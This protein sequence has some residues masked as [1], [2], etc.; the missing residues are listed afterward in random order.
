M[1]LYKANMANRKKDRPIQEI[2][3]TID[4]RPERPLYRFKTPKDRTKFILQTETVC[5]KSLEYKEYIKFLKR[6]ADLRRCTVLRGLNTEHG[7]KYS[8]EIH[9]EPFTLFDIVETVLTR[10][11]MDQE[12][13]HPLDIADEV[14]ELHY[15]GKIGLLHLSKTM[16]QMVHDDKIFIPLQYIYHKYNEFYEEYKPYIN[17]LVEEKLSAK[18]DLSLKTSDILSDGIDPEFTYVHVDG[19]DFPVIPEDWKDILHMESASIQQ[20]EE[21]VGNQLKEG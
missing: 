3:L 21:V 2:S 11:E 20:T 17:P 15:D 7:K 8:I 14:M 10:R 6:N 19:F 12:R 18:V 9:H 4:E 1:F 5:R 16:H 13:I